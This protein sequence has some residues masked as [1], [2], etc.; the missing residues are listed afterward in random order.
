MNSQIDFGQLPKEDREKMKVLSEQLRLP[1]SQYLLHLFAKIEYN[2][3]IESQLTHSGIK[4]K[5]TLL[6]TSTELEKQVQ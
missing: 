5:I 1:I 2:K 3:A 6:D 4:D